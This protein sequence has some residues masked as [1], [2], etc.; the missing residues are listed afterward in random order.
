[1]RQEMKKMK[2][3]KIYLTALLVGVVFIVLF[4]NIVNVKANEKSTTNLVL[5]E[6]GE[7]SL[8]VFIIS[9]DYIYP[10]AEINKEFVMKNTTQKE[11]KIRNITLKNFKI[12]DING[13]ELDDH[14]DSDLKIIEEFYDSI[15]FI[16]RYEGGFNDKTNVKEL[17]K[18][19][20]LEDE[21]PISSGDRENINVAFAMK[22][23][24]GNNMQGLQ[25]KFDM[26]FNAVSFSENSQNTE[27]ELVKTGSPID[28]VTLLW[29]GLVCI[30]LGLVVYFKKKNK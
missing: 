16:V 13:K 8:P 20:T 19:K 22:T 18:G 23:S 7:I 26:V 28:T 24:A 5:S 17:I 29:L 15:Q 9:D 21:I 25:A 3:R 6:K 11:Y 12:K 14:N 2:S 10:G 27:G 4:F 30:V 1:V